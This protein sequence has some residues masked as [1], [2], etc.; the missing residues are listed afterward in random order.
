[1]L[2]FLISSGLFLPIDVEYVIYAI[3]LFAMMISGYLDDASKTPGM[4]TRKG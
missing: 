1:M 3:L 4:N 2:C